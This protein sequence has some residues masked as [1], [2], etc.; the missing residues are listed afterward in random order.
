MKQCRIS[1]VETKNFLAV[2][3]NLMKAISLYAGGGKRE[4]K[5]KH[6]SRHPTKEDI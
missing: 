3:K 6:L 2:F 1:I 4:R 5:T